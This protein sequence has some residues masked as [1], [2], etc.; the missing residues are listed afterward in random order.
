MVFYSNNKWIDYNSIHTKLQASSF[1]LQASSFKLQASSINHQTLGLNRLGAIPG[2]DRVKKG[3]LLKKYI[4]SPKK[5]SHTTT[6][7]QNFESNPDLPGSHFV[8]SI[9]VMY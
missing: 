5:L 1:K 4:I 7:W 9:F 8:V 6:F 2:G 3:V